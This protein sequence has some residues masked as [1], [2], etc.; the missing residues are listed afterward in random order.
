MCVCIYHQNV[1]LMLKTVNTSLNY[2]D[3]LKLCDDY[4]LH[5]CDL[6]TEKTVIHNIL[7]EQWLLNY[8]IHDL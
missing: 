2:M 3:V 8:M 4:M 1:K 6:C 5:H 7:R